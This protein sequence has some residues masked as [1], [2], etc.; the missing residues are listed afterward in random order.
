MK[1]KN[2]QR[3]YMKKK[4]KDLVSKIKS[5]KIIAWSMP[6]RSPSFPG[7]HSPAVAEGIK[8]VMLLRLGFL[9]WRAPTCLAG[10]C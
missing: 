10:L 9:I 3:E 1:K 7:S 4:K 6:A 8:W 5:R 2:S